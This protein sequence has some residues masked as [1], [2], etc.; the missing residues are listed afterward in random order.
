[1]FVYLAS[2]TRGQSKGKLVCVSAHPDF[3]W[4]HE[5]SYHKP[6][7]L[8]PQCLCS[9]SAKRGHCIQD[10]LSLEQPGLWPQ[11]S[12]G[13]SFSLLPHQPRPR[14]PCGMWQSSVSWEM[15]AVNSSLDAMSLSVSPLKYLHR[16]TPCR[17]IRMSP[18]TSEAQTS[19]PGC[20]AS[21]Q[22]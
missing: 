6:S 20:P 17:C 7:N 18:A 19:H 2:I 21:R 22:S 11:A 5:K 1:M 14:V 8:K 12:P 9:L 3:S 10:F 15:R 13:P 4:R 16:V